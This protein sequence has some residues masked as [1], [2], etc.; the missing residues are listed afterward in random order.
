MSIIQC[1]KCGSKISNKAR[2]CPY[3]G[4]SSKDITRP[5]NEQDKYKIVPIFQYEL[6]EWK[7]KTETLTF[8]SEE[9]NKSLIQY[10]GDWDSI[11]VNLPDIA[12]IIQEMRSRDKILVA[13]I[14]TYV[15]DL[16]DKGIYKFSIDKNGEILP[17]IREGSTIRKMVRLKEVNV[18]PEL[19]KPL[20][21]LSTNAVMIRILDEIEYVGNVIKEIQ[22]EMQDD[23]LA[24]VEASRDKLL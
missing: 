14:D 7:P 12:Q 2:T 24:I 8:F 3:C 17:T 1:P 23:R 22:I 21:N 13:E 18:A 6:D 16:I 15:K 19:G 5:I 11:K 4:F 9:D 20:S 10:F